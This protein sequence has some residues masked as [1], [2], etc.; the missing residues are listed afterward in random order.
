MSTTEAT[1]TSWCS[2]R[3]AGSTGGSVACA[4]D[5]LKKAGASDIIFVSIIASPEGI[6]HLAG[7][8]PDVR[9][10]TT[11]VDESLNENGFILPG[12]GDCGDR[13]FGTT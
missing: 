10:F 4:V 13:I 6:D 12:L 11:V 8:H 2:I 7:K 1:G 9:I 3:R 5:L